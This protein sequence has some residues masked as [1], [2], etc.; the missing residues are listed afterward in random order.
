VINLREQFKPDMSQVLD[1]IFSHSQVAKKNQLV[2][3][4]IVSRR[5]S[6]RWGGSG[7]CMFSRRGQKVR[8]LTGPGLFILTPL[9]FFVVLG[10]NSGLHAC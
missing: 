4:L 7:P 8:N 5:G 2:I 3:M 10:L 9:F 6:P 1:C